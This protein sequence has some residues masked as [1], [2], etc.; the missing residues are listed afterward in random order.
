MGEDGGGGNGTHGWL[1]GWLVGELW[2]V[3]QRE[4]DKKKKDFRQQQ[5]QQQE[6]LTWEKSWN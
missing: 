4:P 5:Q 2:C 3:E 1:V 6:L